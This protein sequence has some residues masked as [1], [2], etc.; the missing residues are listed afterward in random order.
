MLNS[1]IPETYEEWQHCIT[2]ECGLELTQ[3]YIE[4]RIASLHDPK[5]Y[6]TQQYLRLYGPEQLQR[7]IAWFEQARKEA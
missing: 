5:D 2:V 7:V 3:K 6:Y 4:A 1:I